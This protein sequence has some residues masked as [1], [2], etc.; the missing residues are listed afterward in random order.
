MRRFLF[1]LFLLIPAAARSADVT[2]CGTLGTAGAT[3]TLQNDVSSNG[4]CFVVTAKNVKLDLNGH[5]V[6]YDNQ[7]RVDGDLNGGFEDDDDGWTLSANASIYEGSYIDPVTLFSGSKSARIQIPNADQAVIGT[8][9]ITLAANTSYAIGGFVFNNVSSAV[10]AYIKIH[11]GTTASQVGRTYRGFQFI[12]A[13][14][15]TGA[16]I[17]EVTV[18]FG[19]SGGAEAAAGHIYFDDIRIQRTRLG[20]IVVGPPSWQGTARISDLTAY[21]DAD[22][23]EVYGGAVT[24]GVGKSDWSP[25]VYVAAGTTGFK[26]HDTT[27]TASGIASAAL[28]VYQFISAE[29]YSNNIYNPM[30]ALQ[31]RDHFD[32]A[33]INNE[34]SGYN[35]L[36]HDNT[37]HTGIQ[38][39]IRVSQTSGQTQN[40]IYLNAITLQTKYTNDFAIVGSGTEIYQNTITCGT[41]ENS[42]RGI[43]SGE[44]A[45]GTMIHNNTITVQELERNQE[46]DGCQFGGAYG[47]QVESGN[48]GTKVYGNTVT[49]NAVECEAAAMRFLDEDD[50]LNNLIYDNSFTAVAAGEHAKSLKVGRWHGNSF[51]V[52][53]N[54]FTT[55]SIWIDV[56]SSG[57]LDPDIFDNTWET[58]GELADPFYPFMIAAWEN[59]HWIG[60][61]CDNSYGEG[62]QARF[63]SSLFREDVS[64]PSNIDAGSY[65]TVEI[66]SEEPDPP[67][68]TSRTGGALRLRGH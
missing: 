35:S 38:T 47:I 22:G 12:K 6:T 44:N 1:L 66:C 5:T 54:T 4:T 39:G 67:L 10:T 46:Y 30:E 25:A 41:G 15:T 23:A 20:G 45:S 9:T 53:S 17:E 11:G 13:E 60:K 42:C 2:A 49:V 40:K 16:A 48:I 55:N 24:Q 68:P 28:K 26:V 36:I 58:A 8:T 59:I 14:Y 19:I 31:V 64:W 61:F 29:I 57:T 27:L 32:G 34:A 18:D 51:Q 56:S 62:D 21:G 65:F 63:E 3:Y 37:I 52:Y 7:A 43:L 33:A 50:A